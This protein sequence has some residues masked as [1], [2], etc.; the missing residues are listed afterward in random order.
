MKISKDLR[1]EAAH[2]LVDGYPGNCAHN[3]GH[4]YKATVFVELA[5]CK[6]DKYGFVKDFNDFKELKKWV[7]DNW[8]HATLVNVRDKELLKFLKDNDQRFFVFSDNPTAENIAVELFAA[9][10]GILMD[11]NVSVSEVRIYETA[12]S[13]AIV[14][15][16]DMVQLLQYSG[17]STAYGSKRS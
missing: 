17:V 12:T 3:H 15:S 4:S 11:K 1:W 16:T 2:R 5:K 6:L 10:Q 14:T 7:D 9:A 8:D 13:E